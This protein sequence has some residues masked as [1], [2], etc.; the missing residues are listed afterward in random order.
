M[1]IQE[2]LTLTIK[3]KASDLHLMVGLPPT[4]RID[5]ALRY[6]T[7]YPALK[8]T[9]LE[10]MIFSLLTPEQKELL[11]TN[12]ELDFSFGYKGKTSQDGGRFRINAFFEKGTLAA[13][14]RFLAPGVRTLE[15]LNMPKVVHE[16]A[17]L[18]Q[19]LVLVTGPT[20]H[21]KSSTLAAVINEINQSKSCH[22]LTIEDPIEYVYPKGNS[23][24]SQRE[25]GID[26][27]S[28]SLALRS[29][30][31]EDPDVVLI[32][33]MRDPET[34]QA[35]ITLA[36]TGH[37]VLSTLHTNSAAQSIDRIVDAFSA[38][39]RAQIRIQLAATLQGIVSQRLI[40]K[41]GGGRIPAVEILLGIPAVASNIRDG[42]SHLIDSVI[43]TSKDMGMIT[44]DD[45]LAQLVKEGLITLDDA[46]PYALRINELE[47]LVG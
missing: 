19:G 8:S 34:M 3:N 25:M 23:I 27:H 24:I 17:K 30:L 14:L 37:L 43:Q 10:T 5:G 36:E 18:K 21:G 26:T 4:F 20:G 6:L 7:T 35:A 13:A 33:E 44:I 2:L 29:S 38:D 1:E 31:R 45:S 41:I 28:W 46:R 9:D 32:G 47:R 42:K 22:I 15:E 11:L 39:Q 40:T 16:F 12:K